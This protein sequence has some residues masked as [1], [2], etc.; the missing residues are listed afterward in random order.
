MPHEPV[1]ACSVSVDD[2]PEHSSIEKCSGTWTHPAMPSN[3][4]TDATAWIRII[5]SRSRKSPSLPCVRRAD[6]RVPIAD[7]RE[8][9]HLAGSGI[10]DHLPTSTKRA[11]QR[12]GLLIAEFAWSQPWVRACTSRRFCQAEATLRRMDIRECFEAHGESAQSR[13]DF[14]LPYCGSID[15]SRLMP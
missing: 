8:R 5:E 13:H 3:A 15:V 10:S 11:P 12:Y 2:V 6:A 14:T 9:L 4:T 1:D 7:V